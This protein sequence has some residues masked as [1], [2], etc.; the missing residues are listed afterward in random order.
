LN[1]IAEVKVGP[2]LSSLDGISSAWSVISLKRTRQMLI[3]FLV[4]L[5]KHVYWCAS[6][7]CQTFVALLANIG[8]VVENFSYFFQISTSGAKS[9]T[10]EQMRAF[11]KVWAEF[12]NGRTGYLERH[13]FVPFFAVSSSMFRFPTQLMPPTQ[14]L[15]GVFEVRVYPVEYSTP[16]ILAVCKDTSASEMGWTPR[17]VDGVDLGRLDAVL[18]GVDYTT[19]RR[20]RAIYSRL[21]HEASISHEQG[22]GM[23]FNGMLLLLAHHK[24][25]VD[26]EAL[27]Y[28]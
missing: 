8:V 25:I 18:S 20:R 2:S 17:I 12:A 11:K 6:S 16:N 21:Y 13:Q 23:S 14:R 22:R 28:V 26:G 10:R 4:Y 1:L 15:S 3:G 24:I 19:I 9:I 5:R 27:V 7:E